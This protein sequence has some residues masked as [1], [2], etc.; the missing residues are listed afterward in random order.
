MSGT[1]LCPNSCGFAKVVAVQVSKEAAGLIKKAENE[2]ATKNCAR[3]KHEQYT[4]FNSEFS[5]A[6]TNKFYIDFASYHKKLPNIR[7][8]FSGCNS[9][10]KEEKVKFLSTFSREQWR[11]LPV[12][13]KKEHSLV[14]C[15]VRAVKHITELAYYSSQN[16]A[17]KLRGTAPTVSQN[18]RTSEIVQKKFM[19]NLSQ[20]IKRDLILVFQ[21]L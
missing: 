8:K 9:R 18:R 13:R 7:E 16:Q 10:K 19:R 12:A 21:K 11:K 17:Q 2:S 1:F 6:G 4:L 15:K 5:E 3:I 20:F 14:N